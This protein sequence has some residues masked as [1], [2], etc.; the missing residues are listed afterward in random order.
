MRTAV[1]SD[2]HLG[3]TSRRDLARGGEGRERLLASMAGADRLILLGDTVELRE[4]PVA[5]VLEIVRPFFESL[6]EVMAGRQVVI[7]PGNHDHWLF[8][9]WLARMRMDGERV[10]SEAEWPVEPGDGPAGRLAS[11]MARADVR[12]AYA[13]LHL[14]PDVYATHGHYLDLHLTVPRLES[15]AASVMGAITGRGRTCAS[16][17]DYDSVLAPMYAFHGELAQG[18]MRGVLTRGGHVSRDVWSRMNGRGGGAGRFLIGTLTIPA[19]VIA[20]N[21]LRLGPFSAELTGEE[22]RRSGLLAMGRVADVLA[23]GAEHVVFGHTHRPGP[24]PGDDLAEWTTLTGARLWNT[25]SWYFES[26]LTLG[27]RDSPYWPGTVLWLEDS[28][29]PQLENLLRDAPV[30]LEPRI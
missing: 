21:R 10:Q 29:P 16:A 8:G 4:R 14:R 1:V 20:L 3:V 12:L 6:G 7:V 5:Q 15:I 13:G 30:A 26:V 17:A 11:W 18:S 24:L 27:A 23:P 22:L 25:G 2:L 19:A 9:P 28:G